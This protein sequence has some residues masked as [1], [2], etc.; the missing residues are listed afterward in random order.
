M[1]TRLYVF[2]ACFLLGLLAVCWSRAQT[3]S[4]PT[5]GINNGVKIHTLMGDQ[6]DA[7]AGRLAAAGQTSAL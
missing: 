7:L 6:H 2:L 5:M 4:H 3:A 1:K